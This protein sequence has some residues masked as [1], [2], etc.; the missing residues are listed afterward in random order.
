MSNRVRVLFTLGLMLLGGT[1]VQDAQAWW[2]GDWAFRKEITF[3]LTPAGAD[4][5]GAVTD[6]PILIRLRSRQLSVLW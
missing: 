1:W 6:V 5:P 3:D 2:S 4:I